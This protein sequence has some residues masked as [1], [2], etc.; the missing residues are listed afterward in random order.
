[1]LL[2][3]K[4]RHTISKDLHMLTISISLSVPNVRVSRVGNETIGIILLRELDMHSWCSA[5]ASTALPQLF[6]RPDFNFVCFPE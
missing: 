5:G 4:A 1:M 2:G 6:G 3:Y